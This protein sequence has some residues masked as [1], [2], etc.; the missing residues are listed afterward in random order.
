MS[1]PVIYGFP[2]STYV[3]TAC[4]ACEEKGIAYRLEPVDF[5][6]EAYR[7][8]HPYQ[9]IPAFSHGGFECFETPAICVYVD[10]AFE[11]PALQPGDPAGKARMWQWIS[12]IEAYIYPA[13]IPNIVIERLVVPMRGGTPDEDKIKA[14]IPGAEY[15]MDTLDR[16]LADQSWL[17]GGSCSV[18]DLILA[19]IMSYA[20][21]SDDIGKQARQ[22]GHLWAWGQRIF[23]R[24]S[25]QKTSP[26]AFGS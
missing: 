13:L 14:A 6:D 8:K 7:R 12:A 17:A 9:K 19:P 16:A 25:F 1:E 11:G 15:A 10:E 2:Q 21:Q 20:A 24:P 18:A 22:R 3:R 5:R 4:M 26:P 23:A